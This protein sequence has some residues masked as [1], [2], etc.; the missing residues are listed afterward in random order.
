MC[1]YF[2]SEYR[3]LVRNLVFISGEAD[4]FEQDTILVFGFA[5]DKLTEPFL[6]SFLASADT[7]KQEMK[8]GWPV[9]RAQKLI[10]NWFSII[11]KIVCIKYCLYT[12]LYSSAKQKSAHLF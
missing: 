1:L 8:S 6:V 4:S 5:F 2:F 3:Y 11:D 10:L 9:V 7:Q 12:L